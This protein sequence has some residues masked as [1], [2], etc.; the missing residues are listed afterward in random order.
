[1]QIAV[2][3]IDVDR[4]KEYNDHHGHLAGDVVLREVAQRLAAHHD[5]QRELLARFGGEEFC[6]LLPGI[7]LAEARQHAESLRLLFAG[8]DSPVTVSIG[9]AACV[10]DGPDGAEAL[11]IAADQ[12]LYEAKRRGRNRVAA[13]DEK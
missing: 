7:A 12:M 2:L 1:M 10:P 6:L 9:V 13:T 4:F 8:E 5:P 3:M 11:L